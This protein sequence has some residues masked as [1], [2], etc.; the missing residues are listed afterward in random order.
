MSKSIFE[1][2]DEEN[3]LRSEIKKI[4]MLFTQKTSQDSFCFKFISLE[5]IANDNFLDWKF[6]K[7][8][9][10]IE[11]L[12]TK[13]RIQGSEIFQK[14][15]IFIYLEYVYNMLIFIRV[16]DY[17]R[18]RYKKDLRSL[19]ALINNISI[20]LNWTNKEIYNEYGKYSIIEKDVNVT[21][22]VEIV[23]EKIALPLLKYKYVSIQGNIE[24]KRLIL[25]LLADDFEAKRKTLENSQFKNLASDLG[26]LFNMCNIRHNNLEGKN[27]NN[28]A[29]ITDEKRIEE[30]YD[31]TYDLYL[32]SILG[33]DYVQTKSDKVTEVKKICLSQNS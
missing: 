22:A 7:S 32:T 4:D 30:I 14:N 24:E 23:D 6:R 15:K 28:F 31:L 26:A 25:K 9:I 1:I 29:D 3:D 12:K 21:K 10:N 27:K 19:N 20:I 2:I 5:E 17:D 11:E 13:L 16:I 33:Y 18:L 8:I